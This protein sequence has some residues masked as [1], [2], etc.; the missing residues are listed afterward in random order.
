MAFFTE[1]LVHT[2]GRWAGSPF[3]PTAWQRDR[4]LSPLF[5][6]VIYTEEIG[7]YVR[8]YRTLYLC[9]ARKNGKTEL[10]AGCTLY[11]LIADDEPGAEV[12]GLALDRDQA[13]LVFRVARQMVRLSPH[14]AEQLTVIPSTGRIS[15]EASGSFYT[16]VA[17]DAPGA[18]GFNPSGAYIDE[19]LT[20]PD[21]ELYD[22]LRTGLGARAQ[23]LL[24]LATTAEND[25][26]GFA[27]SEREWSEQVQADP[28][29]DPERLVV[30]YSADADAD[31]TK[32][33]T[34]RQAN[35]ALGDFL[36]TR[37][38]ESEL[39]M[40]LHNPPAER[41]F[42]QYRLNQPVNRIGRAIDLAVWDA[43]A[44]PRDHRVLEDELAG[45]ICYAGLDL[46]STGDLAAYALDFPDDQGGHDV[47]WRH[48]TPASRLRDLNRRS[49]GRADGW[50]AAGQLTLIEGGVIDYGHIT[51][52]LAR[53]K[54]R[55]DIR[56]V[57][58]DRWGASQ[59][60]IDLM[61]DG[62]PLVQFG[63]GFGSMSGPTK[64]LLRCIGAGVYR[65]GDNGVV[66]W[67]AA[68]VV[69]RTD[70]AGNL[71]VDKQRSAEKV[72]GIVA[73]VMALDRAVRHTVDVPTQYAVAGFR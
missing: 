3:V 38:L 30:V 4:I 20:Q 68:N 46:A 25:P 69:T 16:T 32:P 28:S 57:A 27:A 14:L 44:G 6:E 67:Q 26:T 54:E 2:K 21:R 72:D 50:V 34:W 52:A 13:N 63:Q 39:R 58:F 53:D 22:A 17:G 64:E 11:L 73:A 9:I 71:K 62:W 42:R 23:P 40:A 10:L 61:D 65:H 45:H 7:R 18:L 29:L 8:R 47:I 55:Y 37:V 60:S 31:W 1:L 24:L 19:L 15:H 5:G 41:A 59:L 66:N 33:A 49:G 36:E 56:E 35:P 43:S 51:A 12:Y 48:F 70:P